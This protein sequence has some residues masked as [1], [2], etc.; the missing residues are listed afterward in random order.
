MTTRKDC[1]MKCEKVRLGDLKCNTPYYL[2]D[3]FYELPSYGITKHSPDTEVYVWYE[4]CLDR[5]PDLAS[6]AQLEFRSLAANYGVDA[7]QAA[8]LFHRGYTKPVSI[9]G[10]VGASELGMH[11]GI[12]QDHG[13]VA[14]VRPSD[15]HMIYAYVLLDTGSLADGSFHL[16]GDGTFSL[17]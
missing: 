1:A 10:K 6:P 8:A 15:E 11:M 16:F 14:F 13:V 4:T 3:S 9:H 5:S 12:V 2:T 17:S 7:S